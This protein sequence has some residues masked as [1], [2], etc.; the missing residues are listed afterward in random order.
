[1][2][3]EILIFAVLV[4]MFSFSAKAQLKQGNIMGG[5]ALS[6]SWGSL[7]SNPFDKS[8]FIFGITPDVGYFV[9]DKFMIGASTPIQIIRPA[10]LNTGV[11]GFSPFAR[12]YFGDYKSVKFFF[13]GKAGYNDIMKLVYGEQQATQNATAYLGSGVTLFLSSE[14]GIEGV[15]KYEGTFSEN[16]SPGSSVGGEIGIQYYFSMGSS[17]KK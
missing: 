12:L 2:R 11:F 1:M 3:K 7:T 17:K 9:T 4:F 13:V 5:A 6:S 10:G 15:L 8:K 16:S 14:I